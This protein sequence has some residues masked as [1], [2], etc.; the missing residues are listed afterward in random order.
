MLIPHDQYKQF[1]EKGNFDVQA[2]RAFAV[3]INRDPGIV[4]GRLS[5]DKKVNYEDRKL[6]AL[7]HK[8]RVKI[9]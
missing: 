7:R 3:E 5:N 8:Y 6:N 2:I 1:V 4:F 9:A